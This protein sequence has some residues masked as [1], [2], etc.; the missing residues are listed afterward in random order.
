LQNEL[1]ALND[2]IEENMA[3]NFIQYSKS[4]ADASIFFVKKEGWIFAD[5]R[6]FS[7]LEQ[8]NGEESLPITIDI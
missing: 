1:S 6:R 3:K 8:D 4:P 5:V 7:W 2:Y